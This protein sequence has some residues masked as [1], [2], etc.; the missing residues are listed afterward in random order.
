M[1]TIERR[2]AALEEGI[3]PSTGREPDLTLIIRA[4][5]AL[6]A[7]AAAREGVSVEE[8][9][10]R[11]RDTPRDGPPGESF[12]ARMVRMA[13]AEGVP[14]AEIREDF[15][16]VVREGLGLAAKQTRAGGHDALSQ[17]QRKERQHHVN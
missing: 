1:S 12:G 6:V 17:D 4:A 9:L 7:D 5:K 16:D 15:E 8:I 13:A 2:L 10:A 3:G 11:P 14:V